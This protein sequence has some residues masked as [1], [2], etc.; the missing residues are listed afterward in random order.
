M[1]GFGGLSKT[2]PLFSKGIACGGE[3][4][5]GKGVGQLCKSPA[6]MHRKQPFFELSTLNL[7]NHRHIIHLHIKVSCEASLCSEIDTSVLVAQRKKVSRGR[8]QQMPLRRLLVVSLPGCRNGERSSLRSSGK[9]PGISHVVIRGAFFEPV[10]V[11]SVM[12]LV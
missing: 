1:T 12:W 10:Y 2:N 3:L 8:Q 7:D 4:F 5:C 6:V 9:Q 11:A